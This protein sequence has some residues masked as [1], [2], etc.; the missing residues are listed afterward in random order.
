M[1]KKFLLDSLQKS[2]NALQVRDSEE[3]GTEGH[4]QSQALWA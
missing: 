4:T 1:R 3:E 2:V